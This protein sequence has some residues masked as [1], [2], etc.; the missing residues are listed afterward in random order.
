MD[1]VDRLC[2]PL[3]SCWVQLVEASAGDWIGEGMGGWGIYSPE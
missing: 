1:E 3:A 2:Y